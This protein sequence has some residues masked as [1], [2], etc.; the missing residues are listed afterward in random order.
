M[1]RLTR[2]TGLDSHPHLPPEPSLPMARVQHERPL[3]I[4]QVTE[5]YYPHLGGICEHV[6]FL[7]PGARRR[8][9]HV[10]VIPPNLAGAADAPNLIRVGRS[11][12]VYSNGSLARVT[13]GRRLRR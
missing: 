7:A 8:G 10:D 5:Y 2:K 6:H 13:V 1:P 11:V 9:Q 3:R 12:P 4:A